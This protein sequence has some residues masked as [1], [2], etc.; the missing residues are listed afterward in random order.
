[1]PLLAS[2][3]LAKGG[4]GGFQA[5][6]CKSGKPFLYRISL[7]ENRA[8]VKAQYQQPLLRQKSVTDLI[9]CNMFGL[10]MLAAIGLNYQHRRRGVK[11]D[12]IWPDWFLAVKLDA[13]DLLRTQE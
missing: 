12:Y 1:M 2:P 7:F 5:F 13:E 9:R 4:Q 3:P 8:V 11:I 10:I 6:P